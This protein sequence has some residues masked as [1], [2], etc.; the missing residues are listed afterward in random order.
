MVFLLL[1][2]DASCYCCGRRCWCCW[3][4]CCCCFDG[5]VFRMIDIDQ[6]VSSSNNIKNKHV[7]KPNNQTINNSIPFINS[8]R[9]MTFIIARIASLSPVFLL[10]FIYYFSPF[11]YILDDD[12]RTIILRGMLAAAFYLW[13]GSIGRVPGL[14]LHP[15]SNGLIHFVRWL[16]GTTEFLSAAAA[17]A[18]IVDRRW[19]VR[20]LLHPITND[21]SD[22]GPC[23]LLHHTNGRPVGRGDTLA[24]ASIFERVVLIFA[25][26]DGRISLFNIYVSNSLLPFYYT[27]LPY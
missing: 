20:L 7:S 5:A 14:L 10:C 12:D 21:Q 13:L 16:F 26:D 11:Y 3:W 18:S 4:R 22:A 25:F 15:F 17:T 2:N 9:T 27:L 8:V 23:L 24:D 19:L 6:S 1:M